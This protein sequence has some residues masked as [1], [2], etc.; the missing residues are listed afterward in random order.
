[1]TWEKLSPNTFPK[2]EDTA[3]YVELQH[4]FTTLI[5]CEFYEPIVRMH[6]TLGAG[7]W[8]EYLLYETRGAIFQ[9][10]G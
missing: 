5:F 1:M 2:V 4:V 6:V 7:R 3:R 8:L 10:G 9:E